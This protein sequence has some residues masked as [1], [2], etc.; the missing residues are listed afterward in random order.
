[1]SPANTN[2]TNPSPLPDFAPDSNEARAFQRFVK[3]TKEEREL[4]ARL[5]E[6]ASMRGAL[7]PMLRDYLMSAGFQSVHVNGFIVY[8]REQLWAKAKPTSSSPEVCHALKACGMG[9]FVREQFEVQSLSAH[10]RGLKKAYEQEFA[11]GA[12]ADISE[13][14]PPQLA[15]V[16]N[17][18]PTYSVVAQNQ[19]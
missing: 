9:H 11:S 1:M 7:E 18:Q 17:V 14:L 5:Q 13:I 4:K 10:I 15:A 3:L 19:E 12:I 2:E 8:I 6:V 16:L